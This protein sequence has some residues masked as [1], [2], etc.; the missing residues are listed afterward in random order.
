MKLYEFAA[1]LS[2]L[3]LIF[4]CARMKL[5]FPQVGGACVLRR[6]EQLELGGG[7]EATL[8]FRLGGL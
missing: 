4:A 6:L 5:L 3:F 1:G 2:T 8:L 7:L